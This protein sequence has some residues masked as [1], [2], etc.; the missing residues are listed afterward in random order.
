MAAEAAA[1]VVVQSLAAVHLLAVEVP[2]AALKPAA[3][4][5]QVVE[6]VVESQLAA[7]LLLAAE[8]PVVVHVKQ[9]AVLHLDVAMAAE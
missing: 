7:V 8:M 4:H 5:Q 3:V 6:M 1:A 2:V 9:H